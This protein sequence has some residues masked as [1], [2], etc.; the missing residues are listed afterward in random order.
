MLCTADDDV[1]TLQQALDEL[2]IDR[3]TFYRYCKDGKLTRF[4]H[5]GRTYVRRQWITDYKA[6]LMAAAAQDQSRN[7][8]SARARRTR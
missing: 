3:S 7:A 4:V 5:A 1:L 2:G 8:R 6:K